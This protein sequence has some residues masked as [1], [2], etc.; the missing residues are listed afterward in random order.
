MRMQIMRF[1][2]VMEGY[3]LEY[4]NDD[5]PRFISVKGHR[6]KK[7]PIP[8][9]GKPPYPLIRFSV[10]GVQYSS[11]VHRVIAE[12]LIPFPRPKGVTKKSWDAAPKDIKSAFMNMYLVN[13]KDHN[14]YNWHPSN[15]EW[16]TSREN[17]QKYQEHKRARNRKSVYREGIVLATVPYWRQKTQAQWNALG[18]QYRNY[19]VGTVAVTKLSKLLKNCA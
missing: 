15:L 7:M 14:K 19:S 12:H 16:V 18:G 11:R 13:H 3:F 1:G 17:N 8:T 5:L 10:K 9:S 2:L 6:T 4:D